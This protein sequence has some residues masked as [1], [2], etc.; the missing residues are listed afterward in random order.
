MSVNVLELFD[1]DDQ[2]FTL[3]TLTAFYRFIGEKI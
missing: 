2:T 3:I 1:H